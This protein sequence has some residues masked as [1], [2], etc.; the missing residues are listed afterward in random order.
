MKDQMEVC[1]L[2]REMMLPWGRN[3]YPLHYKA[4]F[5]SSIF[6]YPQPQR[7]T[8]RCA[9]PIGKTVGLPC[10]ACAPE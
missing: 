10:S 9:F 8:L 7:H 4:A 6:L 3:L 2:A 1:P 5:A